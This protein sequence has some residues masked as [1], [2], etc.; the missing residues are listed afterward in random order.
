MAP[1]LDSQPGTGAEP[2]PTTPG[3]G[4][5]TGDGL[6]MLQALDAGLLKLSCD[7]PE[8]LQ[9]GT[10]RHGWPPPG[11]AGLRLTLGLHAQ[12]CGSG[13]AERMPTAL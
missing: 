9:V 1:A 12:L 11:F 13:S 7:D 4:A 2:R 8:M 10:T 5:G 3:A 6:A